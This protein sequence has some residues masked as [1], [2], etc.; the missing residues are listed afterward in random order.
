LVALPNEFAG[1][2]IAAA[3]ALLLPASICDLPLLC[4]AQQHKKKNGADALL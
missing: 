2:G 1:I 3:I 4:A